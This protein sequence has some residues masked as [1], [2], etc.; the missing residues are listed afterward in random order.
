LPETLNS[1]S[2]VETKRNNENEHSRKLIETFIEINF[3]GYSFENC[4][5]KAFQW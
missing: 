3:P 2:L 5:S 4:Y 1:R